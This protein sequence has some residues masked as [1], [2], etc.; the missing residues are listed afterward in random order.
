[1]ELWY[2]KKKIQIFK[3]YNFFQN[4]SE[5]YRNQNFL[6]LKFKKF[7]ETFSWSVRKFLAFRI[8]EFDEKVCDWFKKNRKLKEKFW[9]C[10]LKKKLFFQNTSKT[11]RNQRLFLIFLQWIMRIKYFI[12][13]S[14]LT[15][16]RWV[17]PDINGFRTSG[18][19]CQLRHF[20][21]NGFCKKNRKSWKEW[22][23]WSIQK[24]LK[25]KKK[26]FLKQ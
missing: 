9:N 10:N 24:F 21:R 15:T 20:S 8:L 11:Y 25:F 19:R 3:L 14:W 17:P 12:P 2:L 6:K 13:K 7:L 26:F 4:S 23:T 5:T 16:S 22:G 18:C 1:M